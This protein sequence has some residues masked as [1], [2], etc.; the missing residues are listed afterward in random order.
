MPQKSLRD[1]AQEAEDIHDGLHA[2]QR[3]MSGAV[4]HLILDHTVLILLRQ[5]PPSLLRG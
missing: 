1:I 2:G 4:P 5:I 3:T